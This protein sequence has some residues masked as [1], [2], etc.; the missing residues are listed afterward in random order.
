VL[1]TRRERVIF[2]A[3]TLLGTARLAATLYRPGHRKQA[4]WD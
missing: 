1:P 4:H 2:A 3:Q